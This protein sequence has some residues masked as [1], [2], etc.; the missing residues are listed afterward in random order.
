MSTNSEQDQALLGFYLL[1]TRPFGFE[2]ASD[3]TTIIAGLR[4]V[5]AAAWQEGWNQGFRDYQ[6]AVTDDDG[7]LVITPTKNPHENALVVDERTE[8]G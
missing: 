6:A 2:A 7:Y 5:A 1:T 3:S 4:A 8:K